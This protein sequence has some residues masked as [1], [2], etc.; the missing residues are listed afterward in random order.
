MLQGSFANAQDDNDYDIEFEVDPK[1]SRAEYRVD[2]WKHSWA[3]EALTRQVDK[4]IDKKVSR[5]QF[6]KN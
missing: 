6:V 4:E 1:R 5:Q 2:S 3:A